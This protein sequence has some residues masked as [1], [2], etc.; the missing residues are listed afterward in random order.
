MRIAE[1]YRSLDVNALKRRGLLEPSHVYGWAWWNGD[2]EEIASLAIATESRARILLLYRG[3][4]E[5]VGD[6]VFDAEDR[7]GL[8]RLGDSW[9]IY[10]VALTWTAC[11]FGG[12]RPWFECP[13]RGCGRRVRK[14]YLANRYFACRHCYGLGY[15][16]QLEH[17]EDR[18]LRRREKIARR[19]GGEDTALL[20]PRPRGMHRSM[21]E[22]LA[23][24]FEAVEDRIDLA[25]FARIERL[26]ARAG[27]A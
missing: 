24:E 23:D 9:L 13:A 6:I 25:W 10:P 27:I 3:T 8:E 1:A 18:L 14:L 20:P 11:N 5:Y 17:E 12:S 22:R 2:G 26:A 19:L 7:D 21:Y 4:S 15:A 16:C